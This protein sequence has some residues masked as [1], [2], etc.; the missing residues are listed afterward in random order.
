MRVSEDRTEE[1]GLIVDVNGGIATVVIDR[2]HRMN[3]LDEATVR[4]FQA[5][6][7]NLR[8]ENIFCLIVT[9]AGRKAFSAGADLKALAQDPRSPAPDTTTAWLELTD[10][11]EG[12]P[13]PV[14]AA[15]EGYCMGGGLEL[16]LACDLRIASEGAVLALPEVSVNALPTGGATFRL[17]RVV[18]LGRARE[19]IQFGRR[20]TSQQALE[21]GLVAEVV[22]DGSALDR[23]KEVAV[24]LREIPIQALVRAKALVTFSYAVPGPTARYAAYLADALQISSDDFR[25]GI[26]RFVTR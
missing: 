3:A 18:G 7:R 21:W 24:S 8:E 23:A 19:M 16:A 22:S 26:A 10:Q 25:A 11:L 20:V 14:I 9:G 6:L 2:Q 12:L 17:P 1:S 4:R 13:I 5:L 15:I